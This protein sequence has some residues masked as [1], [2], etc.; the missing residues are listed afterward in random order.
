MKKNLEKVFASASIVVAIILIM[1]LL[2]TAFGGIETEEFQTKLV[3]GLLITLSII[4]IVLSILT[5]ILVFI[6]SDAVKEIIVRSEQS[7]SVRITIGLVHKFVKNACAQIE[8]VKCQK[9]GVVT[10]DYGVR[11]KVNIKV[12]DKDVLE[13]E[14]YLRVLLEDL[15]KGEFGFKFHS[16][17]IKVIQLA[18]KYKADAEE[19]NAKV[20]QKLEEIKAQEPAEAVVDATPVEAVQS[21][22]EPEVVNESVAEEAIVE[23]EA[24]VEAEPAVES[25]A[26]TEA[27][28][29]ET[30]EEAEVEVDAAEEI[31]LE[32]DAETDKE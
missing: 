14:T 4:Y 28:V 15:F 8:G 24:E 5:L 17:E 1:V 21:D 10:D 26:E 9:V 12:V 31:V 19:I 3:Q 32:A 27:A 20:A 7:G 23:P 13:T 22:I 30:V 2:V 29:E 11:L 16:I 18:P 25:E 6:S